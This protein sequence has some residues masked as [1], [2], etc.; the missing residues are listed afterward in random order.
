[1]RSAACLRSGFEQG[2]Y[3][4]QREISAATHLHETTVGQYVAIAE[5]P[6][7]VIAAFRDPRTIALRWS[8]DLAKACREIG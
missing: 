1:M 2:L 6:A 8:K 5:L 7:E 3:K 4:S